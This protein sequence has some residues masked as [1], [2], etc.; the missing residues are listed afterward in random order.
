MSAVRH[1]RRAEPT[2]GARSA[3]AKHPRVAISFDEHTFARLQA[4]AADRKISFG[5]AVR[6]YVG[7]GLRTI[8]S[9]TEEE[10]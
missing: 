6:H 5:S 3:K 8:P 1:H 9:H 4:L 10:A 2:A 7:L